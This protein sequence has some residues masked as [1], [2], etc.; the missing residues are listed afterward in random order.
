MKIYKRLLLALCA[1][2]LCGILAAGLWPFNPHPKNEVSW[3]AN[4]NGLRFGDYGTILSTSPFH[5][6]NPGEEAPCS[7]EIWLRPGLTND[8]NVIAAF[9]THENPMQLRVGQTGDDLSIRHDLPD[10]QG[11]TRRAIIVVNH[12]FRRDK[13]LLITL[14]SDTKTTA[15]YLNGVLAEISR[16][17]RLTSQEFT[18]ELVVG[19]SPVENNSWSGQ[20]WGLAIYKRALTAAEI[21]QH[22]DAWARRGQVEIAEDKNALAVYLFEERAGR[23]VHNKE[24]SEPNLYIPEHYT[25]FDQA[26]LE[27]PWKEF[28]ANW[29]Y[30][31]DIIENVAAFVPL[32][33]FFCAY[34]SS[35]LRIKRAVVVAVL[36]GGM[37]SLTIEVLQAFLPMR[38]SGVTDIITNTTGTAIGAI[39]YGSKFTQ[40]LLS[41]AGIPTRQQAET[42]LE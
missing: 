39:L 24:A 14:T 7:L 33:F 5:E 10:T 30:C 4:E 1:I 25:I 17:F 23:V 2:T 12:V 27:L 16:D 35:V 29:D 3:L 26:F 40:T 31:K 41:K 13:K 18:G 42:L 9:Y 15:V 28:R 20:L 37:V 34:F 38:D 32:G 6:T 11:H 21:M 19:N 8:S 36:L 22:Y